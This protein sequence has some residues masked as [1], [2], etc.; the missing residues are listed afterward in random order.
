MMAK[1]NQMSQKKSLI[2]ADNPYR[3]IHITYVPNCK[4]CYCQLEPLFVCLPITGILEY[5]SLNC[6]PVCVFSQSCVWNAVSCIL[7]L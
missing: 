4:D 5:S 6:M 2:L 1:V 3:S 7:L